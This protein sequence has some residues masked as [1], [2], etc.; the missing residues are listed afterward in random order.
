MW[1][2]GMCFLA[3]TNT[4]WS[5]S[6]K[7]TSRPF[8]LWQRTVCGHMLTL[9]LSWGQLTSLSSY[10]IK[11]MS[12]SRLQLHLYSTG[13][14]SWQDPLWVVKQRCVK[15]TAATDT[16]YRFSMKHSIITYS[17]TGRYSEA[18]THVKRGKSTQCP[19]TGRSE[20]MYRESP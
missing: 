12:F 2:P 13:W 10:L 3:C 14:V 20:V 16:F 11:V 7:E 8:V 17:Q 1:T 6:A 9:P 5:Y 4:S 19:V 18:N 15:W